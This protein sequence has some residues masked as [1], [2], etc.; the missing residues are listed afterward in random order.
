MAGVNTYNDPNHPVEIYYGDPQLRDL[1]SMLENLG[2]TVY[3]EDKVATVPEPDL[4]LGSQITIIRA[5]KINV[6]DARKNYTYHTWQTSITDLLKEKGIELLGQD[7]VSP[8]VTSNL[9]YNMNIVIT[10]VAEV[11]VTETESIDFKVIK[12]NSV[13]L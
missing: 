3:P 12:K 4:G 7:S 1:K 5:T 9:I 10:R 11:E 6:T 8:V 2:V 13:D